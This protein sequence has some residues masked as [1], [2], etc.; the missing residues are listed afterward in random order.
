MTEEA[1]DDK[2]QEQEPGWE[3]ELLT[4]L[5]YAGLVEQRRA[6]RW[7]IFF[8]FVGLGILALILFRVLS[9]GVAQM[10]EGGRHTAVVKLDG[11]IAAGTPA[12]A[13]AIG[14]GL[15]AAFK[16]KGTAGVIL[17][18]N[19]PGG[20]PVQADEI[21]RE[22]RRLR[23]EYPHVPLYAVC[24]DVCASGG[25]YAAVAAQA[26]YVNPAS[27]VGSIGVRMDGF[28]FVGALKKL[29]VTRRLMTAGAH[30]GA[31]DPF[32][33]V[34][35]AEQAHVQKLLDEVHGQFVAAVERGRGKRLS[36][37]PELFS[38]YFWT[39]EDAKRLGLVDGF[40]GVRYVARELIRAPRVVDYTPR[41]SL[42]ERFSDGFGATAA[43]TLLALED[44]LGFSLR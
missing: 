18:I 19:S 21:N 41:R 26:I 3:R 2:Q 40:G 32:E 23:A 14:H 4:R 36:H 44:K 5:A 13:A 43:N 29:G 20:S 10:P 27:I 39:G 8:R 7:S 17:Y 6:R 30:K 22:M 9:L 1:G 38:G 37:D 25:Y 11:L 34:D 42:F 33:P 16:A 12:D 35:P 24:S 31:L 15:R 28:G